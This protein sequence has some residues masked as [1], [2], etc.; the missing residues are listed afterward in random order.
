[1][2]IVPGR[3]D[4]ATEG[5]GRWSVTY[6]LV[7]RRMVQASSDIVIPEVVFHFVIGNRFQVAF[8][9]EQS[10]ESFFA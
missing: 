8:V 2:L 9:I 3:Y 7:V 1:M 5:Q 4:V 10:I 6:M